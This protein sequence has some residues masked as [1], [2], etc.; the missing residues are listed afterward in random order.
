[1]F[2][3][4]VVAGVGDVVAGGGVTG[5]GA[6]ATGVSETSITGAGVVAGARAGVGVAVSNDFKS[7]SFEISVCVTC[8]AVIPLNTNPPTNNTIKIA[9]K[10]IITFIEYLLNIVNIGTIIE[11]SV[12]T[13]FFATL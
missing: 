7:I 10:P 1:V 9:T 12:K 2:G 4:F 13:I 8:G 6:G 3:E 11:L 5:A